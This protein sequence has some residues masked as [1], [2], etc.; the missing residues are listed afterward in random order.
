[1]ELHMSEKSY[2]YNFITSIAEQELNKYVDYSHAYPDKVD[3][4][5]SAF[6]SAFWM[7]LKLTSDDPN[8][9]R[10][11]DGARFLDLIHKFPE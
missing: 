3:E 4:L 10:D 11:A 2:S 5:K 1:M 7:W 9:D 8:Q 6:N